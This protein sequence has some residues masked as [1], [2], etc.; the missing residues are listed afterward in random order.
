MR[1]YFF[2]FFIISAIPLSFIRPMWGLMAWCWVSYMVP[3][4][5][6]WGMT[7]TWPVASLIGAGLLFSFFTSKE[8]KTFPL[9]FHLFIYA[10]F[11]FWWVVSYLAHDTSPDGKQIFT[12]ALKIQL[13]TYV[14]I[15]LMNSRERIEQ[16]FLV[17]T[18][19]I[20][21]FG[22]KGGIFTITT[23]GGSRVWGPPGGFFY[24]NNEL[25][26]TL[27]LIIPFLMYFYYKQQ[28]KFKYIFLGCA[29]LS[30]IS[31]LATYSR[32]ALLALATMFLY[33][34]LH[35]KKKLLS[36][37]VVVVIGGFAVSFLPDEWT[38][39]MNTI[40]AD[41]EEMDTSSLGRINA[42]TMAYNLANENFLGGGFDAFSP[43]NFEI[44]APNPD[45]F[46]DAHSV[47]FQMLGEHGY[48][49]LFLFLM[50]MSISFF[51][52]RS[53]RKK[54]KGNDD[55][56]W[57]GRMAFAAEC[58]II[59]FMSGGVVI[60]LGYF[61]LLYHLIALTIVLNLVYNKTLNE[62]DELIKKEPL[63]MA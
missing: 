21:F 18:M 3:H 52:A 1:D 45:D 25:G 57:M 44:Y 5:L 38:A 47:Y 33:I 23:G 58:A 56:I 20:A 46:H 43:E 60:G 35:S 41:K 36:L 2:A 10:F 53:L 14:S 16:V 6:G 19:S 24:G 13:M 48:V 50:L 42:W 22:V 32:G 39:R 4:R 28:D 55:L 37:A 29:L 40:T 61:D 54:V 15:A 31:I 62:Q 34:W 11:V 30:V 27:I 49:G 8:K 9:N 51:K 12:I 7:N 63:R 59:G 26:Q 17:I